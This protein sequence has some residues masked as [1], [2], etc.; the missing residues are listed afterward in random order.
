M[1]IDLIFPLYTGKK[2]S[3]VG[4]GGSLEGSIKGEDM[5]AS[6]VSAEASVVCCTTDRLY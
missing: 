5:H 4:V 2:I 3:A 6:I 1:L